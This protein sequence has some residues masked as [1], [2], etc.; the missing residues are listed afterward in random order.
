MSRWLPE[1][2]RARAAWGVDAR[3]V[4]WLGA[5]GR[6]FEEAGREEGAPRA[7]A[8]V[9]R[10]RAVDVIAS[11]ELAVHWLQHPPEGAR[12]LAELRLA[13]AARC[14]HLFG[15]TAASWWVAGDWETRRPFVCGAVPLSVA[16]PLRRVAQQQGL[17]LHWHTAWS[18][19]ACARART[20]P[21]HGW[22]AWRSP[23]RVLLWHCTQG[24]VDAITSLVVAA[25]ATRAEIEG[26]L[27]MH[28]RLESARGAA[29]EAA[30]HWVEAAPAGGTEAL[31]ALRLAPLL[32]DVA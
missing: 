25:A 3:S 15:G 2:R 4:A 14:A 28:M 13:A 17:Q 10:G 30:V 5:D 31:A 19:L 16:E 24:E 20:I 21:D 23:S 9:P 7:A 11:G 26:Q 29:A 18:V 12:T 27:D 6:A 1:R 22:S 32:E 8:A